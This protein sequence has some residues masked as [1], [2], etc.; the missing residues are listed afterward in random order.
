MRFEMC[1]IVES[2][3]GIHV[4]SVRLYKKTLSF[5]GLCKIF[6]P[7][8]IF[9]VFF[10]S[11]R[12]K[13]H[14]SLVFCLFSISSE[15]S[16]S[17]R[18]RN[19]RTYRWCFGGVSVI[20]DRI[21]FFWNKIL[22]K[23]VVLLWVFS[24]N[25]GKPKWMVYNGKPYLNGWFGWFGGTTIFGNTHIYYFFFNIFWSNYWRPHRTDFPQKVTEEG[26][27]RTPLFDGNLAWWNIS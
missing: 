15:S 23:L 27:K 20:H 5:V 3:I 10:F 21:Q 7:L 1:W 25:R 13:R 16:Q 24:K 12:R 9:L 17:V 8:I 4:F 2:Y 6:P 22:R 14:A 11:K 19:D 18:S 26:K